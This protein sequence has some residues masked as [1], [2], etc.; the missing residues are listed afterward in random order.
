MEENLDLTLVQK[1]VRIQNEL[2]APKGQFNK[3]GNY[4]Y[5]SCEDIIESVK[6]ILNTYGIMLNISDEIVLIGDRYY[7]KAVAGLTDGT[8][9]IQSC[10]YAREPQDLKGMVESQITGSASSYA[11]KYALNGLLAI[12]DTKDFDTNEIAQQTGQEPKAEPKATPN[13]INVLNKYYQGEKLN[14]LLKANNI[15]KIEDLPMT[16]A[17]ELIGILNKKNTNV[18]VQ[19]KS[20]FSSTKDLKNAVD[21]ITKDVDPSE[22]WGN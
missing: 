5:R 21:E 8:D 6:P 13:Q 7:I 22:I 11:R 19:T 3:F 10:A 18:N 16:K 1:V 4:K 14:K 9:V 2:K 17:S 12:D 15:S 20:G